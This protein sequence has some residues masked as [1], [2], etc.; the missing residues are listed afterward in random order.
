M[1]SNS[2]VLKSTT[3][4]E[5]FV[6]RIQPWVHYVPISYDYSDLHDAFMFFRGD[7]S[8]KGSHDSLAKKIALAGSQWTSTFWRDEDATAYMF[9]SVSITA[10]FDCGISRLIRILRIDYFW[11]MRESS[12]S[13]G[14]LCQ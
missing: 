6:D 12:V 7:L 5:W 2:M 3:Y 13:I 10:R 4:P 14:I 8:G 1:A 11:N 9:R